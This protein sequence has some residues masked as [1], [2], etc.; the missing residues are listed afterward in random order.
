[1]QSI[2]QTMSH[3]GIDYTVTLTKSEI[4]RYGA[5]CVIALPT[6]NERIDLQ[7]G[8]HFDVSGRPR[9]I[10]KGELLEANPM[11]WLPGYIEGIID[12]RLEQIATHKAIVKL[13]ERGAT[14]EELEPALI[15]IKPL[16]DAIDED[17]KKMKPDTNPTPEQKKQMA[18][19]AKSLVAR[20]SAVGLAHIT[21]YSAPAIRM[22][23]TRGRV[24]ASAA[25]KI[26][27]YDPVKK[28]G[29]TRESLR[30]D[31]PYWYVD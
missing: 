12:S 7:D 22:W 4:G 25:N 6:H 9:K 29:F 11:P 16:F 28:A 5:E 3:S 23:V 18:E 8:D 1:M 15:T 31:V 14:V 2:S 13:H 17:K 10:R 27:K 19:Q 21:G 26:C 30:P 24:S 20:F